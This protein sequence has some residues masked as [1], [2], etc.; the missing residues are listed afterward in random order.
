M[1]LSKIDTAAIAANAVDTAAI[2]ADAVTTDILPTGTVIQVVSTEDASAGDTYNANDYTEVMSASITP[3]FS[4]SKILIMYQIGIGSQNTQPMS[5]R[6]KRGTTVVGS[7]SNTGGTA[8][9]GNSVSSQNG[10]FSTFDQLDIIHGQYLD[11]PATTSATSYKIEVSKR[12]DNAA[13]NFRFGA[14]WNNVTDGY[15]MKVNNIITLIEV[16]G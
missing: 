11:S 3:Q 16:A 7:N 13:Q 5:A 15:I 12:N 2:A 8:R 14:P 4:N 9:Y 1:A 6:V 10:D